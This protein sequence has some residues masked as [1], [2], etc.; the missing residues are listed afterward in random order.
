MGAINGEGREPV[1]EF[2]RFDDRGCFRFVHSI[3]EASLSCRI[4]WGAPECVWKPVKQSLMDLLIWS[5]GRIRCVGRCVSVRVR[6]HVLPLEHQFWVQGSQPQGQFFVGTTVQDAFQKK[7]CRDA[8]AVRQCRNEEDAGRTIAAF[9]LVEGRSVNAQQA[10]AFALIGHDEFTSPGNA[11]SDG[12]LECS[13]RV[14][15]LV[16]GHEA[17]LAMALCQIQ[18]KFFLS[19][20]VAFCQ[21]WKQF[22]TDKGC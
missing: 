19:H 16:F 22:C 7:I 11:S 3:D 5:L 17:F 9:D 12:S 4:E 20:T 21:S 8:Q 6:S 2:R 15:A 18:K 14:R 13:Q 10:G 1:D